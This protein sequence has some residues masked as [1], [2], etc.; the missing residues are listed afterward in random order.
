MKP[1]ASIVITT[2]NSA[3]FIGPTIESALKQNFNSQEYE[4][5]VLDDGS[6][7]TTVSILQ[8]YQ[9]THSNFRL[10][11]QKN[12]GP[13]AARTKVIQEARG[14]Y[15]LMMSHDCLAEPDWISKV[16]KAFQK[17]SQVGLVQGKLL[18]SQPINLPIYHCNNF[19]SFVPTFDTAEIAYRAEALDKA[20]RYFD[21]KF[22]ANGDDADLAWRIIESGYKYLWLDETLMHHIV[23]PRRFS[24]DLKAL[25]AMTLFPYLVKIHPS[26]R[27]FLPYRLLWGSKFKYLLPATIVLAVI[28]TILGLWPWGIGLILLGLSF[29][30]YRVLRGT[31]DHQ[32]PLWQK[33]LIVFPHRLLFD[34]LLGLYL[35]IGSIRYRSAIL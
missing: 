20:G 14:D 26:M 18:P 21:S 24:A 12:A 3:P 6:R 23:L 16:V 22:S 31:K 9:K 15:I 32:V 25:P 30:L 17:D 35:I 34:T 13:A 5:L 2:Y 29:N 4:V 8:N 10:L 7:D 19:S 33:V 28:L 27:Q 11:T 1:T